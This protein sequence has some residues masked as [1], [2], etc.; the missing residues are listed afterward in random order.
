[1]LGTV[2]DVVLSDNELKL[3]VTE[4][5]VNLKSSGTFSEAKTID[6]EAGEEVVMRGRSFY[7]GKFTEEGRTNYFEFND[8]NLVNAINE[9]AAYFGTEVNVNENLQGCSFTATLN[10]KSLKEFLAIVD[11]T[12]NSQTVAQNDGS[13]TIKKG[14]CQ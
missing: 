5:K 2:F 12:Y 13:Y 1:M 10:N 4:G 8:V 3:T 11:A 9:V 7:K 6:V 14:V